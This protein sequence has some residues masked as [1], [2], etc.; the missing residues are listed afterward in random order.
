MAMRRIVVPGLSMTALA[1]SPVK[2]DIPPFA[3]PP[4]PPA[5]PDKAVIRG[6]TVVRA[7]GRHQG[8]R[9]LSYIDACASSQTGCEGKEK[10]LRG[11]VIVR[12]DGREVA[13]SAGG[14]IAL[15][16]DLEKAAGEQPIKLNLGGCAVR[17]LELAPLKAS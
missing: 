3:P 17:E 9:W 8:R 16:V 6:L 12:V 2:A 1:L 11:C 15:L 13:V 4:P 10:D 14:N 7:Y 5:G